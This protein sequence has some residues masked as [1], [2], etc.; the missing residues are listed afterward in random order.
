MHLGSNWRSQA[1]CDY[2]AGL[3]ALPLPPVFP[4]PLR[5]GLCIVLLAVRVSRRGSQQ[6]ALLSQMAQMH[7]FMTFTT[8]GRG[9]CTPVTAVT[10]Y[11]WIRQH[12]L[13]GEWGPVTIQLHRKA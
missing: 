9:R 13:R 1:R 4:S 10:H 7:C 5:P 3:E 11:R 12:S 8:W 2:F 6:A